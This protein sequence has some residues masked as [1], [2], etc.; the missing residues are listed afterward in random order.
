MV[1]YQ[2]GKIYMI[3]SLSGD[4]R[5]I[6]STCQKLSQR[7]TD[8]KKRYRYGTL[9]CR[10]KEVLKY[11]DAKIYMILTYPCDSKEELLAMEGKYI[12]ETKGEDAHRGQQCFWRGP[13]SGGRGI[14]RGVTMV[15]YDL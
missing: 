10:S 12:R 5:Y 3:E 8:H 2:N 14:G 4:C 13:Q 1:N 15:E 7:M 9:N 6:G 11:D